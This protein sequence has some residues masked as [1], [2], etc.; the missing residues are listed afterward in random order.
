[1]VSKATKIAKI[2][3]TD[4][5]Y[6]KELVDK[7]KKEVED[8]RERGAFLRRVAHFF[9]IHNWKELILENSWSSSKCL[10]CGEF[11]CMKTG[12]D[13]GVAKF[14][15]HL[16][17][18]AACLLI[19]IMICSSG[20]VLGPGFLVSGILGSYFAIRR[21]CEHEWKDDNDRLRTVVEDG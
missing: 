1:M 4:K 13:W 12:S 9:R 15:F 19:G 14:F 20:L 6:A 10:F 18:G 21:V 8:R 17:G 3:K 5:E 11:Q 7:K 2:F 16:I